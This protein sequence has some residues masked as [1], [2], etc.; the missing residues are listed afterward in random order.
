MS[1]RVD[2]LLAER[3]KKAG[4][5]PSPLASD[6]EFLRRLYLD[7]TGVIPTVVRR[8]IV[9]GRRSAPTNGR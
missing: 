4:V 9:S 7:L 5:E 1:A 3:W 6:A 2:E 8:A